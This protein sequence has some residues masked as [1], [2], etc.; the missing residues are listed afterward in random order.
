MTD[1][2]T[3]LP[4]LRT[5]EL[6]REGRLLRITVNRPKSLNAVNL[7]LYDDLAVAMWFAQ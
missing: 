7:E 1:T 2:A 3:D 5:I 6:A 4:K